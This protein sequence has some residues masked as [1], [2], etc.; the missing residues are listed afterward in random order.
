M[1]PVSDGADGDEELLGQLLLRPTA[2][3]TDAQQV[4]AVLR[5]VCAIVLGHRLR[6]SVKGRS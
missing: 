1:L 5:Q 6:V 2:E 4:A 3:L